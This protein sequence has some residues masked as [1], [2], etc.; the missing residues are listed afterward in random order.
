MKFYFILGCG[1]VT[2]LF[3]YQILSGA[4]WYYVAASAGGVVWMWY[5]T[6]DFFATEKK[7]AALKR[8]QKI[9]HQEFVKDVEDALRRI[10]K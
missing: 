4:E 9:V 7:Y 5:Q 3:V 1:L 6:I 2:S 8:A 10:D